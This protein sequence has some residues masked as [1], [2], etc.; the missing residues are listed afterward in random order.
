MQQISGEN[1]AG[2]IRDLASQIGLPDDD[3][4]IAAQSVNE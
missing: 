1:V 4:H 3:E 2:A